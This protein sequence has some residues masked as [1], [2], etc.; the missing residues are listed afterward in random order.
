MPFPPGTG[1]DANGCAADLDVNALEAGGSWEPGFTVAGFT[2]PIGRAPTVNDFALDSDGALVAAG[3]FR[4]IGEERVPPVVRLEKDGWKPARAEWTLEP[5]ADGFDAVAIDNRG[6]MA[7]ATFIPELVPEELYEYWFGEIWLDEGK[8]QRVIASFTGRVRRMAWY[9]G[10]LWV[11]GWFD[12]TGTD[13]DATF[14]NLAVWDGTTWSLPPGGPPDAAVY[15]MIVDRGRLVMG[16]EFGRVGGIPAERMASYDANGVWRAMDVDGAEAVYAIARDAG[17]EVYIGGVFGSLPGVVSGGIARR[18]SGRWVTLGGGLSTSNGTAGVVTDILAHEDGSI[19]VTGCFDAAGA[20]GAV[21][22][23]GVTR[24]D[25]TAWHSLDD[26]SQPHVGSWPP[27]TSCGHEGTGYVWQVARQRL[28]ADGERVL[29][30]GSFGGVAGVSSQAIVA[31]E[32][33]QW[34]A[35]GDSGRGLNGIVEELAAGGPDCAVHAL[36]QFSLPS[37]DRTGGMVVRLGESGDWEAVAEA[38]SLAEHNCPVLAVGP[39]SEVAIG[40]GYGA[41][42]TGFVKL[43]G[44]DGGAIE[45]PGEPALGP[46][47]A[48]TYDRDGRLWIAGGSDEEPEG[49]VA[50]LEGSTLLMV[51]DGFDAH[52]Q[53]I[54]V[55][56]TDLLAGG[57]FTR[58]GEEPVSSLA[59]WDGTSWQPVGESMPAV[60]ALARD[61]DDVY[62]STV[63]DLSRGRRLLGKLEGESWIELAG[64]DAG[65]PLLKGSQFDELR[66][67]PGGRVV[68]S[69]LV[70]EGDFAVDLR[71]DAFLF[72]RGRFAPLGGGVPEKYRAPGSL[73]IDRDSIWV[74][75]DVT[76][77]GDEELMVPS[78]GVARYVLEP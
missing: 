33:D 55:G 65:L 9:R 44:A 35:E 49:Y 28:A 18:G 71:G 27:Q 54:D 29:L 59:R 26:G 8:G 41:P 77:V 38:T 4:W 70:L 53:S 63:G 2:G 34:V 51:E 31:L 5:P 3:H 16:G 48:L 10:Q 42:G 58:I 11:A 66:A 45:F 25:G 69:G 40:C 19:Y 74:G 62:V 47:R 12:L 61:G 43:F 39:S 67:L 52:V 1:D 73:A 46:V 78:V 60:V 50:R 32:G 56:S 75:G 15:E 21:E 30:G 14:A 6:R 36:G 57:A 24:W 7:L 17:G 13:D 68:A 22:T 64:E 23:S 76:E 37:L 20:G 72:T